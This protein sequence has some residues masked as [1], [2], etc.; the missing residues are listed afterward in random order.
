MTEIQKFD[1]TD[2]NT[3]VTKQTNKKKNKQRSML[4]KAKTQRQRRR[5]IL[6][7]RQSMN[8]TTRK[9]N[10]VEKRQ[11]QRQ[12]KCEENKLSGKNNYD[13]KIK[14]KIKRMFVLFACLSVFTWSTSVNNKQM[15]QPITCAHTFSLIHSHTLTCQLS[16]P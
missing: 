16:H 8:Q 4:E 9:V 2:I 11:T 3:Q 13:Q 10:A 14:R 7:E 5:R 1:R 15:Q 6:K 12:Q